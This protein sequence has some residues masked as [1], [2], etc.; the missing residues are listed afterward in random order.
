VSEKLGLSFK[1]SRELNKII[2]ESLPGRPRFQRQQ[3]MVGNEVCDVYFRDVIACVKALFGD[4]D[5][6]PYLVFVPEKHYV[7]ETKKTRLYHDM[8]T[9]K[10]W[11]ST[12]ASLAVYFAFL[13]ILL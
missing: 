6:A 4:P 5:F 8:N 1:N 2:D 11:W 3:V 12:Q 10:W 7:D 13:N 9:G